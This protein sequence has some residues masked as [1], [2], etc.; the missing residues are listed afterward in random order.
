MGGGCSMYVN[1]EKYVQ[2]CSRKNQG[3]IPHG[4]P[5]YT[6]VRIILNWS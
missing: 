5:K 6:D 1:L 4:R 3:K 2:N